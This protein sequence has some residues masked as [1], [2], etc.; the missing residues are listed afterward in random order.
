MNVEKWILAFLAVFLVFWNQFSFAQNVEEQLRRE[1]KYF[2]GGGKMFLWAPEYPRFLHTPGFWDHGCF[3]D[4]KVEPIFTVTFL[5]EDLNEI[6]LQFESQSWV[7]SHL[8]LDYGAAS[9]LYFREKRA[10]LSNDVLVSHFQIINLSEKPRKIHVVLWTS[11]NVQSNAN[12]DFP[13][14]SK[15]AN[16]ILNVFRG[17]GRISW[18]RI[19]RDD[20]SRVN[21]R[22]GM[23]LGAKDYARSSLVNISDKTWNYPDWKLTPFFEKMSDS[24]LPNENLYDPRVHPEHFRGLL[25]MALY[26]TLEIPAKSSARFDAL[27]AINSDEQ[28]AI[29]A[30]DSARNIEDLIQ[31]NIDAWQQFFE[32]V[33]SF[34]C[35]DPFLQKYYYYRWYGLRLNMVD[36]GEEFRLPYPA[37]FEGINAGWFRHQISYSSQVL[38]RD[39]R[40]MHDPVAAMGSFL[41]F[42]ENQNENGSYPGAIRNWHYEKNTA[43]YHANWG[44]SVRELFRVY[45][46][47]EFLFKSYLS[48]KR[49]AEY[50]QRERDIKNMHLYD[51]VNQWETGQ[52]FMS[53]YL[54]V[55]PDA[56]KGENF[57][58]KGVDATTYIYELQQN[59]AWMANELGDEDG[60]QYW[61]KQAKAT[62]NAIK[63]LMWNDS[64]KFF[65]DVAPGTKKKSNVLAATGFY[66][67]LTDIVTKKHLP[68]ITEHLLNPNE[69]WTEY[70]LPSTSL[71]DP[72]ASIFG[73]WDGKRL[74]CP[75]NGRSWLMTTSHVFDAFA[76]TA[77]TI[78]P[79]LKPGA[80]EF[81]QRFIRMLFLD[82]DI[83]RPTSYE[84][85]N[86]INGKAPFFRGTDDY[87]HSYI[88]DLIIR[89]VVGLQPQDGNKIIIDPLPFDLDEFS[90]DDIQIKGRLLKIL[91]RKRDTAAMDKGL[92]LFID[93]KLVKHWRKLG[94]YQVELK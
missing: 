64:L 51:V 46:N 4:E 63:R 20:K 55:D 92:Y 42:V 35:S 65:V 62:A 73:E 81:F 59:L 53:R 41:N 32:S 67:F 22:I 93:Q 57:R 52:E 11:Q 82:G 77:Q 43:F 91:W 26:Y 47:Q 8:T 50:F 24:G 74:V 60:A 61:K 40:W 48:L 39:L 84:Y 85:Y 5:D 49:Y 15:N 31:S 29:E 17:R 68:A 72:K 28:K 70:P 76:R 89:Y 37:V 90:L 34:A 56:D 30:F 10:L 45:P 86:P 12:A 69:F 9:N 54:F 27:C 88:I 19:Y 21:K 80:V 75:W 83:N 36:A 38:M 1:D 58:L 3:L 87:M 2:L 7:P 14:E 71:T 33:P 94:R 44:K 23:A 79:D 66:P 78:A 6:P 18:E 25:Y 16:Y 13:E